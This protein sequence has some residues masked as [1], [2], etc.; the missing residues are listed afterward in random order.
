MSLWLVVLVLGVALALA[1]LPIAIRFG[2]AFYAPRFAAWRALR[3]MRRTVQWS[4][5]QSAGDRTYFLEVP[6]PKI[7]DLPAALP[8]LTHVQDLQP[9]EWLRTSM[10]T[11]ARSVASILPGHFE[12]YARIEHPEA[13]SLSPALLDVLIEHLQGATTTPASCWFAIWEGSGASAVPPDLEPKLELPARRY[14]VFAG[15]IEGAR[16]NFDRWDSHH[17]SANLWWPA[18]HAWC[19]AS[20]IDLHWSYV[21]GSRS[22]IESLLADARLDAVETT[23]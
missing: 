3:R 2:L 5:A 8:M 4:T 22:C 11:F 20:E 14:H 12:A 7:E 1:V 17:Q 6:D 15:P 18:D 9:A 19:V 23:A 16:S 21:G 10:T 13:R